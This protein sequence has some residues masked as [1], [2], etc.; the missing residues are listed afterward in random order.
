ME[1]TSAEYYTRGQ[2]W[3]EISDAVFQL[4]LG[5]PGSPA[6]SRMLLE[7][8]KT[9][10]EY[11]VNIEHK[12]DQE[13]ACSATHL[14]QRCLSYDF[15]TALNFQDLTLEQCRFP[16][17]VYIIYKTRVKRNSDKLFFSLLI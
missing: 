8:L 16:P 4:F 2:Y 5:L 6:G 9:P 1:L 15:Y 17:F 14:C 12:E 11:K 10:H 3:E 13:T 7:F